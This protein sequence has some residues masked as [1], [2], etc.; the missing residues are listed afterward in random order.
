MKKFY[1]FLILITFTFVLSSCWL[2]EKTISG[3]G[4]FLDKE[5]I[6]N[7]ASSLIVED[8]DLKYSGKEIYTHVFV[9]KGNSN[10]D[11]RVVVYGQ[12]NIID[13]INVKSKNDKL[14]I[15]GNF[16]E[17]YD[18]ETLIIKIYGY[19]FS[20]FNL[21][22]TI[23]NVEEDIKANDMKLELSGLTH[24][25]VASIECQNIDVKL[26][27][28][29][30]IVG[31]SIIANKIDLVSSGSSSVKFDNTHSNELTAKLSNSS[32]V[33]S[34]LISGYLKLELSGSS[35]ATLSG[36]VSK[37]KIDASG[38][39][40]L[41]GID[42][43]SETATIDVSGASNVQA[44]VTSNLKAYVTGASSLIYKG[45]CKISIDASGESSV[46]RL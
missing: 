26:E 3:E 7:N 28:S 19:I 2:M 23:C 36:I 31:D 4:E 41:K 6:C 25:K 32:V 21:K 18:T 35:I 15:T 1:L 30:Q 44:F 34:K 22:N 38:S 39:S 45:S 24:L 20:N 46:K 11:F 9:S 33:D 42:L 37:T 5:Y 16:Y 12:Q 10:D 29:A 14:S 43:E 27:D 8:I 13:S 40:S 17:V